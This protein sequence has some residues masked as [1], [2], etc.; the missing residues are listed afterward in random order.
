MC[1]PLHFF[2]AVRDVVMPQTRVTVAIS[3]LSSPPRSCFVL[4]LALAVWF[5]LYFPFY[6]LSMTLVLQ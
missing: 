2:L 5:G 4:L 3:P 6:R 1:V